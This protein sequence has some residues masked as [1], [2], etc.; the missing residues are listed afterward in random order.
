MYIYDDMLTLP[1]ECANAFI[2]SL[3][4]DKE[5]ISNR[6]AFIA[7]VKPNVSFSEDGK[8]IV[9]DAADINIDDNQLSGAVETLVNTRKTYMCVNASI[10]VNTSYFRDLM[11]SYADTKNSEEKSVVREKTKQN[12]WNRITHGL[13]DVA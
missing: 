3:L 7:D 8:S 5:N 1:E 13:N 12:G 9:V 11:R 4:T 6:N 2:S 10:T